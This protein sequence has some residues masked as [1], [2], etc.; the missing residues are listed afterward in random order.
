MP[1]GGS[2]SSTAVHAVTARASRLLSGSNPGGASSSS[3]GRPVC[4]WG[5]SVI[6][7]VVIP[8]SLSHTGEARVEAKPID[9]CIAPIVAALNAAAVP[10]AGSCCGHGKT[11]PMI[12]LA[13]GRCVVIFDSADAADAALADPEEGR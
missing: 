9:A 8:A 2:T 13:D 6:L 10:T 4:E 7:P 3:G 12:Q 1:N 5:T 11:L